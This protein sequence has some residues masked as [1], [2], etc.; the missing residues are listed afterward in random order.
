MEHIIIKM[1]INIKD[2]GIMTNLIMKVW[3]RIKMEEFI[4]DILRIIKWMDL[5]Y[6]NGQIM[7]DTKVIGKMEIFVAREYIL[8]M[9][10]KCMMEILKKMIMMNK[11]YLMDNI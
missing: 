8:L 11:E 10:N 9:I 5:E 4:K 6:F 2:S 3:N 7:K 1:E